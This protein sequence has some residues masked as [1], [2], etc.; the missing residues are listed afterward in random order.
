[1]TAYKDCDECKGDPRGV[2]LA[3]NW[4]PCK[5]CSKRSE[6]GRADTLPPVSDGSATDSCDSDTSKLDRLGA[7]RRTYPAVRRKGKFI[8]RRRPLRPTKKTTP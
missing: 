7:K 5:T 1:M 4:H 6:L 8:R 3:V 2:L